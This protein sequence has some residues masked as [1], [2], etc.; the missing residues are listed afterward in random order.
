MLHD[1]VHSLRGNNV[2]AS[3]S[4][5]IGIEQ[6]RAALQNRGTAFTGL[7]PP[8]A[9]KNSQDSSIVPRVVGS[10]AF[11]ELARARSFTTSAYGAYTM[12]DLVSE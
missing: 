10:L 3:I 12:V 9:G 1:S 8:T 6:T 5:L 2:R 7:S 4:L 11:T